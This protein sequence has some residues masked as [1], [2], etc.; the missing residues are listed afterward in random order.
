VLSKGFVC[1]EIEEVENIV[2]VKND[3]I[4]TIATVKQFS[5]VYSEK[6]E[7]KELKLLD[8]QEFTERKGPFNS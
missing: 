6:C 4:N 7:G 2:L 5:N 3:Q 8:M 1:N